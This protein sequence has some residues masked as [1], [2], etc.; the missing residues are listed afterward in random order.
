MGLTFVAD[1]SFGVRLLSTC[2]RGHAVAAPSRRNDL[3]GRMRLALMVGWFSE[4]HP[5]ITLMNT[6]RTII[7][8]SVS[9]PSV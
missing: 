2:P 1:C 6:D 4:S 5:R 3:I 9:V 7:L 8:G